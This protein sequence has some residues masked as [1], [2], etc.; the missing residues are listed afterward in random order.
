[1]GKRR[2]VVTGLGS[3]TSLGVGKEAFWESA[4][5]GRSGV[6]PIS[7]FDAT[8]FEARIA[9]YVHDFQPEPVVPARE[10]RRMDRY[11]QFA[12]V[13]AQEAVDDAGADFERLDRERAGVV[14]GT[15]IGGI[16]EIED[17][18]MVLA[19]RG[20]RRISPFLIP[21]L[22]G[23]SAAGLVAIRFGLR[24]PNAA[25]VTACASAS[26][27]IGNAY[28]HVAYD[29]ADAMVTGGSEAAVT[30]LGV[31]GFVAC[32]ALSRRNDEPERASRPFDR[33]RDGFVMGE[34][35]GMLVLEEL[36]H[37]KARGARIYAEVLGFGATCDAHHITAPEPEGTGAASCMLRGLEDAGK[38][39]H[40]V[41]YINAHGTSTQ[42][43]DAMETRAIKRAFGEHAPR[44]PISSTK[45][46]IGH[47]LGASGGAE[48][49]STV[50]TVHRGV[51]PPTI[52]YENPDPEC[53]LD[54][55]PNQARQADVGVA[56]CNSFGFGGH[57]ATVVVGKFAG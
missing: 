19:E 31:A 34:G 53:D 23:N 7:H 9:S 11:A 18:Q 8:D 5:E 20:P 42:L 55:V 17:Q 25:A 47:L 48:L 27:A 40:Q 35:A 51:I 28:F 50:L 3:I 36:D 30:P 12:L 21:K 32:K 43:N 49:V 38:A 56:L 14:L 13:A 52:N 39:P 24:G 26:H 57:N 4:C 54:Y 16:K 2:V 37:A 10:A 6:R 29:L 45:S 1:M 15:G 46:M 41:D 33:E 44:V 22:M